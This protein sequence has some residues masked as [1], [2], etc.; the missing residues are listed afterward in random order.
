V[1]QPA[2]SHQLRILRVARLVKAHRIG[3]EVFYSLADGH[4]M[5]LVTQARSHARHDLPRGRR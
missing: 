4:V 1:S 2:V 3:R 5:E